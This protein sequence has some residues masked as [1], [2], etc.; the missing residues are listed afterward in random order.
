MIRRHKD[1]ESRAKIDQFLFWHPLTLGIMA[2]A[3]PIQRDFETDGRLYTGEYKGQQVIIKAVH[4]TKRPCAHEGRLALELSLHEASRSIV[5]SVFV[6]LDLPQILGRPIGIDHVIV[7]G[8]AAGRTLHSNKNRVHPEVL[9]PVARAYAQ[10]HAAFNDL[11]QNN[12]TLFAPAPNSP[13][14]CSLFHPAAM[15]NTI[16]PLLVEPKRHWPNLA[17]LKKGELLE[18]VC[19][20]LARVFAAY[21]QV[22]HQNLPVHGDLNTRN[23]LFDDTEDN[24]TLIDFARVC[25]GPRASDIRIYSPK[26]LEVFIDEYRR[27]GGEAIDP[28]LVT[29]TEILSL[30]Y[31][32]YAGYGNF[33]ERMGQAQGVVARLLAPAQFYGPNIPLGL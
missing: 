31:Q 4:T 7:M 26:E 33:F 32:V 25:V 22:A 6:V 17:E 21:S 15:S 28:R 12:P 30:A 1:P 2:G 18:E 14:P 13:A 29:T 16:E 19:G 8:Q 24:V 23:I 9:R 11:H 5:P 3:Q 10:L 27:H 20:K